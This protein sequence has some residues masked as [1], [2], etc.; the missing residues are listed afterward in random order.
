MNID[1]D[2]YKIFQNEPKN[3][4]ELQIKTSLLLSDIGYLC[5]IEKDIK[6]VRGNVNIDVYAQNSSQQP[7]QT[8]LAECKHWST[9]V[10]KTVIH[11]FRTVVN[12]SGANFGIIISKKGFQ[13][14]AKIATEKTNILLFSWEEFQEYFKVQWLKSMI[15]SV[16]IIGKPLLNFT[17][18]LGDFYD[19][20]FDKLDDEKKE[21][22]FN[23]KRKYSEFAFYCH[24]DYYLNYVNGDI[25]YLDKAIDER[26]NKLPIAIN[27]YSDYFYFIRDYCIKGLVEFDKLFG[28]EVRKK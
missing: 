15:K 8:L 27:C 26:K 13:E 18:Y 22:F 6:T 4:K 16:H 2:K 23:I 12:D 20:E 10:P 7:S 21:Q 9:N 17:D 5:E 25:E 24:K 3:W 14:G 11:S 28:K 1:I 19:K